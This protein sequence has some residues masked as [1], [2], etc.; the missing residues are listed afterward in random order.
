[1]TTI[2][3]ITKSAQERRIT[4]EGSNKEITI[5]CDMNMDTKE[6]WQKK[7]WNESEGWAN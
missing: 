3:T 5:E 4:N 7:K 1:M 6:E 2:G